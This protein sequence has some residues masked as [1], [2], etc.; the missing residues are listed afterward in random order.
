MARRFV[1]RLVLSV[2]IGCSA[3]GAPAR[4]QSPVRLMPMGDSIVQGGEQFASFRYPLWLRTQT[5]APVPVD[6]VG[7]QLTVRGGDGGLF[8]NP[9]WYPLYYAGFDRDHEG[10]THYQTGKFLPG[11]IDSVE[12]A[13]P[14]V[15][16]VQLGVNDIGKKGEAG[17]LAAQHNLPVLVD[18]I[19]AVAGRVPRRATGSA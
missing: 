13:A 3:L 14:D 5:L 18:D 4:A 9:P 2:S 15:V 1:R 11:L 8:P 10:Y 16:I 12:A 7:T 6:F 19:R 17:L